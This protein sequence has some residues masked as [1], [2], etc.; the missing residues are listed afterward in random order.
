MR[1]QYKLLH[2]DYG[3][4]KG[5]A[6]DGTTFDGQPITF[7]VRQS[8]LP[9]EL[10]GYLGMGEVFSAYEDSA[11]DHHLFD[12]IIEEGPRAMPQPLYSP[13]MGYSDEGA[14]FSVDDISQ[15]GN[16][17]EVDG[18]PAKV[19]VVTQFKTLE[20]RVEILEVKVKLLDQWTILQGRVLHD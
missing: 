15:S 2:W 6:T 8:D 1:Q 12:V 11:G 4:N 20:Q 18:Y 5:L 9:A 17:I 13:S 7:E 10:E 3:T 14:V 19:V 16:L